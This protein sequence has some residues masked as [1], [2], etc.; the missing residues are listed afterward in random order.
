MFSINHKAPNFC[1][2][3]QEPFLGL[4]ATENC[5]Y[6]TGKARSIKGKEM[7][8]PGLT[9][10]R[11][12][13]CGRPWYE[14]SKT[15]YRLEGNTRKFAVKRHRY[16]KDTK[17]SHD[18]AARNH[19]A[20]RERGGEVGSREDSAQAYARAPST[21]TCKWTPRGDVSRHLPE[22]P[23]KPSQGS[24]RPDPHRGWNGEDSTPGGRLEGPYEP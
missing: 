18:A 1:K 15:S 8:R 11:D 21:R 10:I 17:T 7:Y 12:L 6:M 4:G 5:L 22:L 24:K 3:T 2:K 23:R 19:T 20:H 14:D 9:R 13:P 16:R